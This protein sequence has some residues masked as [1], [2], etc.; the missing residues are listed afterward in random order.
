MSGDKNNRH[1][2]AALRQSLLE[3]QAAHS[4]QSDISDYQRGIEAVKTVQGRF[5]IARCYRFATQVA[6]HQRQQ[7]QNG[8]LVIDNK[9]GWHAA[10]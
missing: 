4:R 1:A 8:G 6:E 10:Y 2:H 7:A 3:I 9:N 5:R